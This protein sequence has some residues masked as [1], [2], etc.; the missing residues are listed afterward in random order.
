TVRNLWKRTFSD[1][2]FFL[3]LWVIL[4]FTFFSASNSKLPHYILP[5]YPALAMLTGWTVA[6][7]LDGASKRRWWV[8]YLPWI[9]TL[10]CFLYLLIG[11]AW[12]TL[13]PSPIPP[14]VPHKSTEGALCCIV[15]L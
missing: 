12:P 11:A 4:P 2:N 8:L 10:G 14:P 6:V 1:A 9:F 5:I 13:L 3:L 7:E 15:S